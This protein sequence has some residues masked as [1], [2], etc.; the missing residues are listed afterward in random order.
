MSRWRAR[1]MPLRDVVGAHREHHA[2]LGAAGPAQRAPRWPSGAARRRRCHR[3]PQVVGG[4]LEVGVL[5]AAHDTGDPALALRVADAGDQGGTE[6]DQREVARSLGHH[7]G[8]EARAEVDRARGRRRAARLTSAGSLV[9]SSSSRASQVA[10]R[11]TGISNSGLRSTN[12]AQLLGEPVEG[13]LLVAPAGLEL[14][15]A[16]VGEVHAARL[17]VGAASPPAPRRWRRGAGQRSKAARRGRPAPPA[18]FL[19]EPVAGEADA[20]LRETTRRARCSP[21][22]PVPAAG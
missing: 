20:A 12:V 14:L 21:C 18:C 16:A 3:A 10:S 1:V 8:V 22:R 13:D 9:V 6:E 11:S 15:D 5:R 7:L 4:E 17:P 2:A 19:L